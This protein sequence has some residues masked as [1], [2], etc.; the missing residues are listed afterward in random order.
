MRMPRQLSMFGL[1]STL[2]LGCYP[3]EPGP[4]AAQDKE[5]LRQATLL[6]PSSFRIISGDSTRLHFRWKDESIRETGYVLEMNLN[7]GEYRQVL[8][9][10]AGVDSATLF[11]RFDERME[12]GFRLRTS[13]DGAMSA[14]TGPVRLFYK[15]EY[16][17]LKYRLVNGILYDGV[18]RLSEGISS[19][20]ISGSTPN[21]HAFNDLAFFGDSLVAIGPFFS[22]SNFNANRAIVWNGESWSRF[23][24]GVPDPVPTTLIPSANGLYL[25]SMYAPFR[26]SYVFRWNGLEFSPLAATR[27]NN[28]GF[29]IGGATY[30][31][32]TYFAFDIAQEENPERSPLAVVGM[33]GTTLAPVSQPPFPFLPYHR[34]TGI[35]ARTDGLYLSLARTINPSGHLVDTTLIRFDGSTWSVAFVSPGREVVN[36]LTAWN[37]DLFSI[38][39]L[40]DSLGWELRSEVQR[41]SGTSWAP[42]VSGGSSY[43][44]LWATPNGLIAGSNEDVSHDPVLRKWD[45]NTWTEIGRFPGDYSPRTISSK[46][47]WSWRNNP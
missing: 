26:P 5:S 44:D 8:T 20:S 34:Q 27:V 41:W 11:E 24:E 43:Y 19:L 21:G 35:A 45:G 12:Y 42:I 7:G 14:P 9:I 33:Q 17:L 46:Q 22:V 32:V 25:G 1:L 38:R 6:P 18:F 30:Q 28:F 40:L 37:D 16:F 47:S 13:R 15:Q 39:V 29:I 4:V 2:L 3:E 31:G 23:G 10:P 36:S